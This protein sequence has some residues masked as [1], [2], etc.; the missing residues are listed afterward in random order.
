VFVPKIIFEDKQILVINKPS[1]MVV[2]RAETVKRKTIQDWMHKK[3]KVLV[4]GRAG[5][6]QKSKVDEEFYRRSGVVHRLDKETSGVMV[7]AKTWEALEAL[8]D[9]FKQRKVEKDYL[10]L[11]HGRVAPK[12]GSINLPLARNPR[13]RMRFT[14]K[15]GGRSA[16]SFYE[17]KRYLSKK[18]E[19]FSLLKVRPKTGRT[20]Q[21]R[22]HLSFIGYPVVSD[23][24][25]LSRKKLAGDLK[26]CPRL[27]LHAR[28]LSFLHPKARK[29]L[30][31]EAE[32]P[33]DLA[34]VIC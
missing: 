8:K 23:S 24:L 29:K 30:E 31:F 7:L 19:D 11:V 16:L 6:S 20:H 18:G 27:F 10:A 33:N 5:V 3:L 26:W 2:N 9:E 32:L 28:R 4:E 25:Y 15:V 21:I 13:N 14:V 34:K 17:V 1:G 12:K 22:V